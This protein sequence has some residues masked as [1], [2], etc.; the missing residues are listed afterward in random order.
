MVMIKVK[1]FKGQ[2]KNAILA[3]LKFSIFY[4]PILDKNNMAKNKTLTDCKKLCAY[5]ETL[6]LILG[7]I[8][9]FIKMLKQKFPFLV[10]QNAKIYFSAKSK[11]HC[12]IFGQLD[13]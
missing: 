2:L 3:K 10:S 1:K 13:T 4:L 12:T 9:I 7:T 5:A 6:F 11:N 8:N